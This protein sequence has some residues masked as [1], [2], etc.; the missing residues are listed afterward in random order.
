MTGYAL[1][2]NVETEYLLSQRLTAV[3]RVSVE[4]FNAA[5]H[6]DVLFNPFQYHYDQEHNL[7][8]ILTPIFAAD[9]AYL[10]PHLEHFFQ[11]ISGHPSRILMGIVGHGATEQHI[12][13]AYI[14]SEN[15]QK[16]IDVFD[17]KSS[18]PER[19]FANSGSWLGAA[20]SGLFRSLVPF[21]NN[22]VVLDG[23]AST[24]VHYHSLGTQSY[25]DGVSCG[26]HNVANILTCRKI[27]AA[28]EEVSRDTILSRTANP[29][30]EIAGI[31]N[32][33]KQ[34]QEKVR[35]SFKEFMS[36]AWAESMMPFTS[37]EERKTLTI[38]NYFFG[39]P[40]ESTALKILYFISL[41]FIAIPLINVVRRT[42]V[43]LLNIIAES[44]NFFKNLLIN[45]APTHAVTQYIR[46]GLLLFSLGIQ[47]LFK[48]PSLVFQA[49]S[50]PI[51]ALKRVFTD[52]SK[53]SKTTNN[54]QKPKESDKD[55]LPK[56]SNVQSI[57]AQNGLLETR[58]LQSSAAP[59]AG[60]S[61]EHHKETDSEQDWIDDFSDSVKSVPTNI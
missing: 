45:W 61:V 25:F 56:G 49:L 12:A 40:K 14:R 46:S 16:A 51:D 24:T 34:Y 32:K 17:P 41:A 5:V 54:D 22:D 35:V 53:S 48:A 13:T 23:D 60:L 42:P 33:E 47:G 15:G 52:G 26:Y 31:L 21:S 37:P 6:Q 38:A 50:S 4:Q 3:E 44:A 29:V 43:L 2:S 59:I 57:F 39:W 28:G 19:F 11:Q 20:F 27:I 1:L 10:L 7:F 8:I 18:N 30:H 58:S 36:K 55:D 9:F